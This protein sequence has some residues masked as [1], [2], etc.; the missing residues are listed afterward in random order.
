LAG[1]QVTFIGRFWVTAEGG[2]TEGTARSY[3]QAQQATHAAEAAR[4]GSQLP[5][6]VNAQ[7]DAENANQAAAANAGSQQQ[8]T[9]A[10][11]QQKQ[12]N[13]WNAI[14]ALSGNAQSYA[15]TSYAGAVNS[16]AGAL[17]E[18]GSAY[19]QSKQGGFW[20]AFKTSLGSGLGSVLSGGAKKGL[21]DENVPGF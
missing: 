1:F 4:G 10:N 16:G 20:N 14:G 15:P 17:G 7:I 8:I 5:S 6:G 21:S 19:N 18:L 3:A 2:A 12:Q 13:Y 9:L 11:E